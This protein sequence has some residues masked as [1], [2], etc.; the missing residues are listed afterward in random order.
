AQTS[1]AHRLLLSRQ[2]S[3]QGLSSGDV[4]L[5]SPRTIRQSFPYRKGLC[6]DTRR[7]YVRPVQTR[8]SATS[9]WWVTCATEGTGLGKFRRRSLHLSNA[10]R[11]KIGRASR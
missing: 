4:F 8:Y 11:P 10:Q 9:P 6:D 2:K 3:S 5:I 1:H 7:V